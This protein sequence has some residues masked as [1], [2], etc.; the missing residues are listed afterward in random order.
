MATHSNILAWRIQWS[1]EPGGLLNNNPC[2]IGDL[3]SWRET[4]LT[5]SKMETGGRKERNLGFH[6]LSCLPYPSPCSD[7]PFCPFWLNYCT[8]GEWE[9]CPVLF[10]SIFVKGRNRL[11]KT[12]LLDWLSHFFTWQATLKFICSSLLWTDA[13][14]ESSFED[15]LSFSWFLSF[16]KLVRLK[17]WHHHFTPISIVLIV[18][19]FLIATYAAVD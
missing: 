1:E 2:Q 4:K 11:T 8:E 16:Q 6:I 3:K 5:Q 7:K 14:N 12:K 18:S 9:I 10:F 13:K 17:I 19:I 15:S